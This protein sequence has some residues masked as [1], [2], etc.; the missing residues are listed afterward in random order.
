MRQSII[1]HTAE[2]FD[3]DIF[4]V[5]KEPMGLRGEVEETLALISRRAARRWCW[6]CATSWT[7]RTCRKPNGSAATSSTRS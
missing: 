2:T 7:R 4:I 6:A 1:R 5:D 3:P